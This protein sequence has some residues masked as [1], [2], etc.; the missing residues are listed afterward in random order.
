MRVAIAIAKESSKNKV[1]ILDLG[2][3]V[4]KS[5]AAKVEVFEQ[6]LETKGRGTHTGVNE[7]NSILGLFC[8]G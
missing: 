8:F 5:S 4:R 6:I 3:H 1:I 2:T 7:A